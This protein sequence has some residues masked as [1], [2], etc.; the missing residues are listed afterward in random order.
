MSSTTTNHVYLGEEV[1]N[2]FPTQW[3]F[4]LTCL[5]RINFMSANFCCCKKIWV[6]KTGISSV[7]FTPFSVPVPDILH[8]V[9]SDLNP[10]TREN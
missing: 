8:F 3:Q 4:A 2:I 9:V 1:K 5:M 10:E 7:T 6:S